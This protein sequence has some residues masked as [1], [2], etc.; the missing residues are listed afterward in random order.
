MLAFPSTL[1]L[2]RKWETNYRLLKIKV[3]VFV[4][5][6]PQGNIEAKEL[7]E[8]NWLR[9]L[10]R[11][12][13]RIATKSLNYCKGVHD[14]TWM[15]FL[16]PT[17]IRITLGYIW[18]WW[19]FLKKGNL[20]QKSISFIGSSIWNKLSNNLKVLNTTTSFNHYYKK[21]VLQNLSQ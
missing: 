3:S 16:S 1:W 5:N 4:K 12:G 7:K 19:Y 17:E 8:I 15:N 20:G 6:S 10:E 13:Q 14:P 21:L 9:T 18:L 11:V 2:A